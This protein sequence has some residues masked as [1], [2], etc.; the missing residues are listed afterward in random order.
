MSSNIATVD[1]KDQEVKKDGHSLQVPF[2]SKF[3]KCVL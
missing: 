1:V 3:V 2:V